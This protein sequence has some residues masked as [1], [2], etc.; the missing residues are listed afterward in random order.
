LKVFVSFSGGK[1]SVFA[2]Y[3]GLK[4]GLEIEALLTMFNTTGL[5][6]RG[7]AL[8]ADFLKAQAEALGFPL[9]MGKSSW[10]SYERVFKSILKRL[11][12]KGLEG[13][14]FGDIY[15]EEH[16]EWVQRV[17][18]EVGLLPFLPLWGKDPKNVF[19]DFVQ[20]GFKAII[21]SLQ[22]P[23]PKYFIG[24]ELTLQ[25]LETFNQLQMDPC[26]ERGEYHTAVLDGP[27]FKKKLEIRKSKVVKVKEILRL[28]I[29]EFVIRKK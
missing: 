15:L 3:Q 11:K 28:E 22:P 27:I 7:H 8:K 12:R 23:I 25:M 9:I 5:R 1:E 10:N 13:G 2:L 18:S 29:E 21:I 20:S 24:K 26:G 14:I 19:E 17:C 4:E 6:T 16:K